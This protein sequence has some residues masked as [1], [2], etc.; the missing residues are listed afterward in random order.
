[1]IDLQVAVNW[2]LIFLVIW[3]SWAVCDKD[4]KED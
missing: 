4:E 2:M 3:V 1:M